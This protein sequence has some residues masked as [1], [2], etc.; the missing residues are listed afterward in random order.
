MMVAKLGQSAT[1]ARPGPLR[2]ARDTVAQATKVASV[3]GR[4][5]DETD[6]VFDGEVLDEVQTTTAPEAAGTSSYAQSDTYVTASIS[7]D[8][9]VL[10]NRRIRNKG[11]SSCRVFPEKMGF[12]VKFNEYVPG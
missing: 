2:V 6:Q 12:N 4:A 5:A 11:A 10:D 3:T 8:G 7:V 9:V 1:R